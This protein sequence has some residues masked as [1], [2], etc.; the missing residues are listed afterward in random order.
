MMRR[1][2]YRSGIRIH[3]I[4]FRTEKEDIVILG[5]AILK[6]YAVSL[7]CYLEK[8]GEDSTPVRGTLHEPPAL[9]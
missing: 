1:G 3:M 8:Q 4:K 2:Q 6:Y 5:I 7:A 9:F